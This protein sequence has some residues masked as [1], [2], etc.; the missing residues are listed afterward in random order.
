M[1]KGN[2]KNE[3]TKSII[4]ISEEE[5]SSLNRDGNL[6]FYSYI[7]LAVECKKIMDV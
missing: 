2:C 5:L 6:I 7:Y 4:L 3:V 1:N